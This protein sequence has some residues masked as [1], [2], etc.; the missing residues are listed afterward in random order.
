MRTNLFPQHFINTVAQGIIDHAQS[1]AGMLMVLQ[2]FEEVPAELRHKLLSNLSVVHDPAIVNFYHIIRAEYGKK[3]EDIATRALQKLQMAGVQAPALN[4]IPGHFSQAY[5]TPTRHLGR[6]NLTIIWEKTDGDFAIENFLLHFSGEGIANYMLVE[7]A[8]APQLQLQHLIGTEMLEVEEDMARLLITTAYQFNCEYANPPALGLY[9][10]HRY[11]LEQV[12]LDAVLAAIH[13]TSRP[14]SLRECVNTA[15]LA[16]QKR[17]WLYL[18]ALSD[19]EEMPATRWREVFTDFY[20]ERQYLV[21]GGISAVKE[22][23]GVTK[24]QAYAIGFAEDKIF[25]TNFIFHLKTVKGG[26][27]RVTGLEKKRKSSLKDHSRL[28]PLS[29]RM[30]CQ[31]YEIL[32]VDE[33]IA[34]LGELDKVQEMGEMPN[35]LHV[36]VMTWQYD[37]EQSVSFMSGVLADLVVGSEELVV[38]CR[39]PEVLEHFDQK[40]MELDILEKTGEYHLPLKTV[41]H[42]LEGNYTNLADVCVEMDYEYLM[43]EEMRFVTAKYEIGDFDALLKFLENLPHT[44]HYALDTDV[45]L[46]H[47]FTG[48]DAAEFVAEYILEPDYMAISGFGSKAVEAVCSALENILP[49]RI[50]FVGLE[51]RP[52]SLFDLLTPEVV[53]HFPQMERDF[54]SVYLNQWQHTKSPFLDGMSPVEARKT[55]EGNRLL[56]SMFKIIQQKLGE[57][58]LVGQN[59]TLK[60]FMDKLKL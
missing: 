2:L 5:C 29:E 17:D 27:W 22:E 4:S 44:R 60:E 23:Q 21:E 38:I 43:G 52:T 25:K 36:R 14:E 15:F 32:D 49:G 11:F 46:Y 42:Y 6:I 37:L 26:G 58:V 48:D 7:N 16:L 51:A 33:L 12:E 18:A 39:E 31:T 34:M 19:G 50:S 59:L 47:Q 28:N 55:E 8:G 9:L 35:G 20:L 53:R 1:S 57:D 41:L 24:V 54:K 45:Y 10:Y 40:I 13:F 30:Y 56:W 3:Y